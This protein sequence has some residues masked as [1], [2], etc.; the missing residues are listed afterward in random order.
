[1]LTGPV[2]LPPTLEAFLTSTFFMTDFSFQFVYTERLW[3]QIV[4]DLFS[5]VEVI[6]LS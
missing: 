5:V 6:V 2:L 4:D 1:V 3:E